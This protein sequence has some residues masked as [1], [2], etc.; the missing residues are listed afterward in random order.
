MPSV[1]SLN[2]SLPKPIDLGEKLVQTGIFKTPV[3][4]ALL[5]KTGFQGDAQADRKNHG[6]ADQAVYLYSAEDYAWWSDTLGLDLEPGTFGENLTLSHFSAPLRIG[7][8]F[9]LSEVLLEATSP[10][11]P[12]DKLA[13]KMGDPGFVKRFA[14]AERPGVYTRVLRTGSV[15]VGDAVAHLANPAE[16]PTLLECFRWF[17]EKHPDSAAL[18]DALRAPLGVRLRRHLEGKLSRGR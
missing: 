1:L 2:L 4:D 13:A 5:T 11:I 18:Q 17:Y 3:R 9:K 12:C 15:R 8:R 6:G 10:R 16:A 14:Q 7:D